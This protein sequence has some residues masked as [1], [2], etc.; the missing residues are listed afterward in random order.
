MLCVGESVD[1]GRVWSFN[2]PMKSD[3]CTMYLVTTPTPHHACRG[4]STARDGAQQL[5]PR[6]TRSLL[7]H[8]NHHLLRM[9]IPPAVLRCRCRVLP[10]TPPTEPVNWSAIRLWPRTAQLPWRPS[11]QMSDAEL[12]GGRTS[13]VHHPA[14]STTRRY[15]PTGPNKTVTIEA[16]RILP[17]RRSRRCGSRQ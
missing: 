17:A 13:S 14:H 7:H 8:R 6:K 9:H 5:Q 12:A 2:G 16:P 11:R 1:E 15:F 10:H 4:D 3:R